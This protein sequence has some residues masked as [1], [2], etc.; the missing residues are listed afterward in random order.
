[1]LF[2]AVSLFAADISGTWAA[3]VQTDAGSGNPVFKLRQDGE[4]LTGTYSGALGE[5]KVVGTI[6]G[7][8]VTFEF[9]AQ[10]HVVY[11]GKVSADGRSITGAVDLGGQAKGTFKAVKQ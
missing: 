1:M 7:A 9:D 10:V 5:A 3:D 8:E 6:K 4:K 2:L 11:E